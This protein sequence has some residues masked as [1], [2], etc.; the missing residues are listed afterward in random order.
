MDTIAFCAGV[1]CGVVAAL[2]AVH[3]RR[4]IIDLPLVLP[5]RPSD[6]QV[7]RAAEA[8]LGSMWTG[9]ADSIGLTTYR[10]NWESRFYRA[11]AA[12]AVEPELG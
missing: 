12:A 2:V 6:A 11:L 4:T 8:V 3:N 7:E 5:T 10:A 1:V 9:N